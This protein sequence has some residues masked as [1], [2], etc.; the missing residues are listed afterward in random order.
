M[1]QTVKDRLAKVYELVNHGATEGEKQAAK[2]ALDRIIA[3]YNIDA[4]QLKSIHLKTYK[5]SYSTLNDLHLF[6]AIIRVFVNEALLMLKGDYHYSEKT[7]RYSRHKV[8]SVELTYLQYVKVECSY[9]YFRRHMKQQWNKV[10]LPLINKC[11]TQKGKANRRR[12]LQFHFISRYLINS[13][14]Y[15]EKDLVDVPLKTN[16]SK[17]VAAIMREI[18][19]GE[20]STQVH[21]SHLLTN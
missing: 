16:K 7:G 20:Y 15:L 19:G 8:I 12:E 6:A 1:E 13:N 5:F 3:K 9:E 21:T 11:R 14:L 17:E 2:K 4:E 18:E 10:V